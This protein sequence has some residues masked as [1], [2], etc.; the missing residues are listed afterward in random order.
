MA[1]LPAFG[2]DVSRR[3]KIMRISEVEAMIR[4]THQ[5]LNHCTNNAQVQDLRIFLVL[6]KNKKIG[7]IIRILCVLV[8]QH[9]VV[10]D[11]VM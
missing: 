3:H 5:V 8:P 1:D 11:V 9:F 6:K 2:R 10:K 4:I 7:V